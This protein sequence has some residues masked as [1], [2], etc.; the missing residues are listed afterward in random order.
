M[1]EEPETKKNRTKGEEWGGFDP[2]DYWKVGKGGNF[3]EEGIKKRIR[4]S[5]LKG[6]SEMGKYL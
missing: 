1:I 2:L 4:V 6:R 5:D 3:E